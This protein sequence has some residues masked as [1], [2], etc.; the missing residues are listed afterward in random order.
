MPVY[1]APT[2]DT[3]F[4]VNELIGLDGYADLPGFANAARD[5]TD[6]VIEEGGR[7]VSEVVAPLNQIGDR[8]GCTR[9]ADGSVTTPTGFKA[10]YRQYVEGGWATLSAPEEFGGQGLPHVI[11]FAME[12]FLASAN[13]AFAMYPGLA[14]SSRPICPKWSAANGWAQ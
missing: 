10:A 12:E 11:G 14:N 3:R 6:A 13:Q 2:R 9:H 8:E 1:K 7:F 5:L 4:V